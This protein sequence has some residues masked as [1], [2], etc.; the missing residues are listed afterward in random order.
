MNLHVT[1]SGLA[2]STKWTVSL[3]GRHLGG[4]VRGGPP[5]VCM[6]L[7]LFRHFSFWRHCFVLQIDTYQAF[8]L[9]KCYASSWIRKVHEAMSHYTHAFW[10]FCISRNHQIR[11]PRAPIVAP[12]NVKKCDVNEDRANRSPKGGCRP[13]R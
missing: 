4:S 3:P 13:M 1:E 7:F 8:R 10:R 2:K 5:H 6:Y 9:P 11:H 12:S